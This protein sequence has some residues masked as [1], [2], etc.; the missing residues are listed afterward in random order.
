MISSSLHC[1]LA[2][3]LLFCLENAAVSFYGRHFFYAN[4]SFQNHLKVPKCSFYAAHT[5]TNSIT[6]IR[7]IYIIYLFIYFFN[8]I[9][10][11][12]SFFYNTICCIV[13]YTV[14]GLSVFKFYQNISRWLTFENEN[15]VSELRIRRD[16]TNCF[17][18]NLIFIFYSFKQFLGLCWFC[19]E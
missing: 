6:N 4:R 16:K 7:I 14:Y 2:L 15:V 17:C 9:I 8:L 12:F 3:V 13:L 18:R 19:K 1:A 11:L 5:D 10:T